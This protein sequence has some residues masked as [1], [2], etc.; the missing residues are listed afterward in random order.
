MLG[1]GTKSTPVFLPADGEASW[2]LLSCSVYLLSGSTVQP[3]IAYSCILKVTSQV[4]GRQKNDKHQHKRKTSTPQSI[5]DVTPSLIH[6][7][8]FFLNEP[9]YFDHFTL[10]LNERSIILYFVLSI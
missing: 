1:H 8:M 7:Q 5:F 4:W 2:L 6:N 3:E 9:H 10:F